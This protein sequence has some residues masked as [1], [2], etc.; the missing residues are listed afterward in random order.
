MQQNYIV[1][2]KN[3]NLKY[4]NHNVLENVN[5]K[6]KDDEI[7]TIVG[8]NGSGKTSLLLCLAGIIK[9][10]RS[11]YTRKSNLVISYMPQ[12]IG[13][14]PV[15]PITVFS[16]LCLTKTK[17]KIYS[18]AEEVGIEDILERQMYELS[19]GEI[20]RVLLANCL[21]AQPQLM[22]L[23]EP[24]SNMDINSAKQFYKLISKFRDSTNCSI[25]M[26]SHDLYVVMKNTDRVIC[27]DGKIHCEGKPHEV[28]INKE[29][30]NM[31]GSNFTIYEHDDHN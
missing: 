26:A 19:G 15:L 9:I 20:Q 1:E 31:F 6:I 30:V 27:L 16:F 28:S 29:F 21:L 23:D 24:V 7:I 11:C 2:L 17:D 22:I 13:F 25:V 18:I 12:N 8:P 4:G 10:N 14:D 5:L 3:L